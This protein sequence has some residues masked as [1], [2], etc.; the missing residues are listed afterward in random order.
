VRVE[1]LRFSPFWEDVKGSRS[2]SQME[3]NLETFVSG[4]I[5]GSLT[6]FIGT[7]IIRETS[8]RNS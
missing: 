4:S 6:D 3:G 8:L 7:D 1:E 5:G 2:I